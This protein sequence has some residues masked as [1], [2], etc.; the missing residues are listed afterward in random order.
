M[1]TI[2][3]NGENVE[4]NGDA[5]NLCLATVFAPSLCLLHQYFIGRPLKEAMV[6]IKLCLPGIGQIEFQCHVN[7]S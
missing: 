3:G 6:S 5:E 2:C 1:V 7:H 4:I